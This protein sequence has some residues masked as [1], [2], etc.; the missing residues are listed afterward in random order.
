MLDRLFGWTE[1]KD[2]PVISYEQ[3]KDVARHAD[4][5]VRQDLASRF[6]ARPEI[7]YFLAA[8]PAAAVRRAVAE[9]PAAPRPA[10]KLLASDADEEVRIVLARKIARLIPDLDSRDVD[11]LQDL[12]FDI[13]ETL[14][15]D[16]LPKVRRIVAE[17]IKSAVHV[18]RDIV[19]RLARDAETVVCAPVLQ[20]SVL[21]T[22]EDLL[23]VVARAKQ[24]EVLACVSKRER[25]SPAVCEAIVAAGDEGA[26]ASL[27]ANH[28]AQIREDTLDSI[29]D[30]APV[31]EPWHRPLVA[32]PSLS[33]SAIRR[34]AGF[35]AAALLDELAARSDIDAETE[36]FVRQRVRDRLR[37]DDG[38]SPESDA[39]ARS[40]ARAAFAASKLDDT[41]ILS[42]AQAGDV[43][44][45]GHALSLKS[46]VPEAAVR[47]ILRARSGRP[48]SALCW[49]AHLAMRTAVGLQRTLCHLKGNEVLN[50]RGGTDY[51]MVDEEMEWFV[52]YFVD[53]PEGEDRSEA[54]G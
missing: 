24:P 15:Q 48:L 26:I 20:Y 11:R 47:R 13:L 53:A 35:V 2:K 22:D 14:A 28:G 39:A 17:E 34:I 33:A 40:R 41:A 42:A 29:I 27:L 19:A 4:P 7:L 18:P 36:R 9:N 10:E 52:R 50:P 44:F 1:G 25:L 12:T 45:V 16:Q 23:E 32:R 3:E 5:A 21:L 46:G 43:V 38:S 49:K 30:E 37:E 51:P 31:H 6:D 8:D 54:G